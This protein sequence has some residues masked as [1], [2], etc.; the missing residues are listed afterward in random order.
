M[1]QAKP[2]AQRQVPLGGGAVDRE[3]ENTIQQAKGGGQ[4]LPEN[5]RSSME[6]AFGA[7]F[8]G[9]RV[10]SDTQADALNSSMSARAFTTGKDIFIRQGEYNPGSSS[11]QELLAHEL[12]HV[13]QQNGVADAQKSEDADHERPRPAVADSGV[14]MRAPK[15]GRISEGIRTELINKDLEGMKKGKKEVVS[16]WIKDSHNKVQGIIKSIKHAFHGSTVV[17]QKHT[18]PSE[19]G[20]FG[21]AKTFENL[22]NTAKSV[23]DVGKAFSK[24]FGIVPAFMNV[25]STAWS[26]IHSFKIRHKE[27]KA[28]RKLRTDKA[29]EVQAY[30]DPFREAVS[31]G[32]AQVERGLWFRLLSLATSVGQAFVGALVA[33][34]SFVG[35][36]V[37]L[38]AAALGALALVIGIPKA[39]VGLKRKWKGLKKWLR[40]ERGTER[41]RKAGIIVDTARKTKH[42]GNMY[43][44]DQ[45]AQLIADLEPEGLVGLIKSKQGVIDA[46]KGDGAGDKEI[47][48]LKKGVADKLKSS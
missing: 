41:K 28:L 24:L 14:V 15:Q 4:A 3:A 21:D 11:G 7:D 10:H 40:G 27:Y 2:L 32:A 46:L 47:A 26:G 16:N 19:G 1:L 42:V 12:T 13:V 45:A 31:Y 6:G 38:A 8:S 17:K 20:W 22:Q 18:K 5:V 43:E 30:N 36:F 48:S 9:V 34:A 39:L 29:K 37:P 33:I 44:R 35:V 23:E 25:V